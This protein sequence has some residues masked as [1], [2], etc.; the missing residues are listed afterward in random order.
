MNIISFYREV[1]SEV[2]RI[3]WP[4][5]RETLMSVALVFAMVVIAGLFFLLV[6]SLLFKLIKFILG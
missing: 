3:V 6:D 4:A 2:L 1:K 5:R